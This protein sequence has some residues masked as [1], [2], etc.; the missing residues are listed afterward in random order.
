M[1]TFIYIYI[2][3]GTSSH[4][5]CKAEFPIT[6]YFIIKLSN[7]IMEYEE[8]LQ[9]AVLIVCE[10]T[11][12]A[13]VHVLF[14][15]R[16]SILSYH[17]RLCFKLSDRFEIWHTI[18]AI[19][20][21]FQSDLT[22]KCNNLAASRFRNFLSGILTATGTFQFSTI[23]GLPSQIHNENMLP[24]HMIPLICICCIAR[25]L[26]TRRYYVNMLVIHKYIGGIFILQ[27]SFWE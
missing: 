14:N 11:H 8:S 17:L 25:V 9:K 5:E 3:L 24:H 1:H 23:Y 13:G 6:I 16:Y 19:Y 7:S 4:I 2:Y 20:V 27:G 22:I 21:I 10:I 18:L 26:H 12:S 15:N